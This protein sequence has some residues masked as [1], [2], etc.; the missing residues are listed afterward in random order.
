LRPVKKVDYKSKVLFDFL[1]SLL[2]KL[3]IQS[4]CTTPSLART[5]LRIVPSK[6]KPRDKSNRLEGSLSAKTRAETK[7]AFLVSKQ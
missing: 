5:A 6:I 1:F 4:S 7:T 2:N 3:K